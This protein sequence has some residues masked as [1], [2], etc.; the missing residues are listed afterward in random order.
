MT[1]RR[2]ARDGLGDGPAPT[3]GT[4]YTKKTLAVY[5]GV[6]ARTL[7]RAAALGLLPTPDLLV[8]RSPRWTPRT[9]ETWLSLHP[10]LPGRR[11]VGHA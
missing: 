11:G 9:V 3:P 6:S 7:D 2:D 8:G 4:C 1:A 10:R 5:L